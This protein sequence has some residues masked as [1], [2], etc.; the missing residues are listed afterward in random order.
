MQPQFLQEQLVQLHFPLPLQ[1]QFLSQV[2]QLH[3]V[4]TQ[5]VQRQEPTHLKKRRL[6][7]AANP[8]IAK[9][10]RLVAELGPSKM[11]EITS[12]WKNPHIPQ[13]KPP[14]IIN[15]RATQLIHDLHL[16]FTNTLLKVIIFL[17]LKLTI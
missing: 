8:T 16:H 2:E 11:P 12:I 13:F 14:I 6:Q 15:R 9:I 10:T 7:R 17:Y 3:L 4:Q 1:L 5:F